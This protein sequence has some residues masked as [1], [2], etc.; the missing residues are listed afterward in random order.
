MKFSILNSII[1]EII[2]IINIKKVDEYPY[3]GGAGMLISVDPVS[4]C[5]QTNHD[6]DEL[7]IYLTPCGKK[8]TQDKIVDWTKK[9]QKFNIVCGHYEGFDE[10]VF[11][12]HKG[13]KISV[14]DFICMSGEIC[15][16]LLIEA[17]ARYCRGVISNR[18]SLKN[19]SFFDNLLEYEQYTKPNTYK[20][21]NVPEVLL[22]GHHNKIEIFR[23]NSSI[24]QT[25]FFRPDLFIKLSLNN[26]EIDFLLE[27]IDKK[28]DRESKEDA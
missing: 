14:G 21:M 4:R 18:D 22:S 19:E 9:Y 7:L 5:I 20:D 16:M 6:K 2:Q 24:L 25:Y 12:L 3:G 11:K 13:E 1:L 8:L 28:T 10:R 17:L 26:K 15:S 23:K 27:K